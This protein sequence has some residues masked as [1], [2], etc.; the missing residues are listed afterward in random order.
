MSKNTLEAKVNV[1]VSAKLPAGH[2]AG[3]FGVNRVRQHHR[4]W[5]HQS[6]LVL[7]PITTQKATWVTL[8]SWQ[9]VYGKHPIP[10]GRSHLAPK[11]KGPALAEEFL[12][13]QQGWGFSSGF[14]HGL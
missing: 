4:I 6:T 13:E 3:N 7:G 9:V 14:R 5:S 11:G 12:G 10:S 2:Q 8:S 1:S